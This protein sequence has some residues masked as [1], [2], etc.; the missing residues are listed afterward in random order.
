MTPIPSFD[1]SEVELLKLAVQNALEHLRKANERQGGNDTEMLE[2]G[3]RYALL[4]QK[5]QAVVSR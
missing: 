5:L 4:L 3:R 1:S 2:T